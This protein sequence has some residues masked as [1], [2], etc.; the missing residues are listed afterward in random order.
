M[1]PSHPA[2]PDD[3]LFGI[4]D[5]KAPIHHFGTDD[6]PARPLVG[7]SDDDRAARWG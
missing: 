5:G 1:L 6:I 3:L 7:L 4:A 2:R